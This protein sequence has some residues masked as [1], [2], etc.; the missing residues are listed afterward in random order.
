MTWVTI[1]QITS[2]ATDSGAFMNVDEEDLYVSVSMVVLRCPTYLIQ[3]GI[4]AKLIQFDNQEMADEWLEEHKEDE[5]T[6]T[7]LE[8]LE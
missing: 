7:R 2:K 1:R 6:V 5:W 3:D 8:E 4:Y